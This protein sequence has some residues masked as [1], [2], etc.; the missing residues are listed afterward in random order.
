MFE[1]SKNEPEAQ[2]CAGARDLSWQLE[3]ARGVVR[4]ELARLAS[5]IVNVARLIISCGAIHV[6]VHVSIQPPPPPSC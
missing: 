2:E 6:H 4:S 5:A 1:N 3:R